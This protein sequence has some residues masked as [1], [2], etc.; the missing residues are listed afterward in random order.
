MIRVNIYK[1]EIK[2][3]QEGRSTFAVV[4]KR[5]DKFIKTTSIMDHMYAPWE[6]ALE[7]DQQNGN[8]DALSRLIVSK[9]QYIEKAK[10]TK[11]F[12]GT[13]KSDSEIDSAAKMVGASYRSNAKKED[14]IQA[15]L[16]AQEGV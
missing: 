15:I 4:V 5:D 13:L 16:D 7:I 1:P 8:Q 3:Y 14:R 6:E 10:F 2:K 9:G 12:L 11:D